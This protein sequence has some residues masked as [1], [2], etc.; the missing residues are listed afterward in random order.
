MYP[1]HSISKGTVCARIKPD[2]IATA[3]TMQ[4]E[5]LPSASSL[6]MSTFANV[7][8]RKQSWA[9]KI[10]C[11]H[12]ETSKMMCMFF[13]VWTIEEY[14][15]ETLHGIQE[16]VDRYLGRQKLKRVDSI[17]CMCSPNN[18]VLLGPTTDFQKVLPLTKWVTTK[19]VP[20]LD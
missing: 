4:E 1:T 20:V 11:S 6:P 13:S 18:N 3:R 5:P 16:E 7:H 9:M 17:R 8:V 12:P 14:N 10:I 15:V 19:C 2:V